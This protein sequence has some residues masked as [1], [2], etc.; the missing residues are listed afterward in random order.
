M[1]NRQQHSLYLIQDTDSENVKKWKSKEPGAVHG[2]V[3]RNA[4]GESVNEAEV[5]GEGFA[6]RKEKFAM[7]SGVFNNPQG[8]EFH[9]HR[10]RM[11]ELSEHCVRKV[12]EHW[13]TASLEGTFEVKAL[14]KD[15][16]FDSLL[17]HIV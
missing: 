17:R 14:L 13:Q 3:Y 16:E 15:F 1:E 6:I 7:C 2:A 4:F 11:H 10:R 12:V 9:D 8:S 5:V